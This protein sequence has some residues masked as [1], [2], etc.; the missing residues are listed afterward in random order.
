MRPVSSVANSLPENRQIASTVVD[1]PNVTLHPYD[2]HDNYTVR[3]V[4]IAHQTHRPMKSD[5]ARIAHD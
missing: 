4:L 2:T 3:V 5:R 1:E